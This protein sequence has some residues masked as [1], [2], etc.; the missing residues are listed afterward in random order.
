MTDVDSC[1]KPLAEF[2]RQ[3]EGFS[4]RPYL[5]PAGV[6]TIG[7]GATTYPSGKKVTMKDAPISEETATEML[8]L[9]CRTYLEKVETLAEDANNNQ[10]IALAS[11]S[12]NIGLGALAKSTALKAHNAGNHQAA[13][14]AFAL[15]NKAKVNGKLTVMRG[16]TARRAAEA[17]LYL[18]QTDS[19]FTEAPVQAVESESTLAKSP[20]N[21]SGAATTTSGVATVAVAYLS[22][23]M[24]VLNQAKEVASTFSINPILVLGIVIIAAGGT[25]MY[26][27]KKQREEGWA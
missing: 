21:V 14:R 17:A 27:R 23:Y 8:E 12:Y 5:C 10:L 11:L 9:E 13:A 15:W 18:K 25:V 2:L 20:I 3:F 1:V 24:P 6:P 26:Y 16:L 19:P 22:E 4:S 7:V